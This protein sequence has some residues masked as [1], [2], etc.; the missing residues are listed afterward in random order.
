MRKLELES[1]L[2]ISYYSSV[3]EMPAGRFKDF[4]KYLFEAWG[5]G[6]TMADVDQRLANSFQLVA[7]GAKEKATQELM[8][9]RV[10]IN[11]IINRISI[12][13]FAFAVLIS[14]FNG[15]KIVD[16]TE[17]A[18]AELIKKFENFLSQQEMET[19]VDDV[20]KNLKLI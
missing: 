13:S 12:D 20:K 2:T 16:Y 10:S 17:S 14:E 18:L 8:N 19:I 1:E 7:T 5:V 11:Y 15:E 3:K 4:Q 9:L 6:N